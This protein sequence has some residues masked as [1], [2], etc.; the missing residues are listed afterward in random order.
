[1]RIRFKKAGRRTKTCAH[2]DL[3][4]QEIVLRTPLRC[5]KDCGFCSY[6]KLLNHEMMH[7]VLFRIDGFTTFKKFD[8]I[9]DLMT[10]WLP[11]TYC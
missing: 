10:R 2:I 5:T 8:N 11:D 9:V 6:T 7:E 3:D 1:M 4:R